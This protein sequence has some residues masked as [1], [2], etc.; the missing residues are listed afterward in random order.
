V[1]SEGL[2]EKVRARCR[3]GSVAALPVFRLN[4]AS[5]ALVQTWQSGADLSAPAQVWRAERSACRE[6]ME[7]VARRLDARG[8]SEHLTGRRRRWAAS[9]IGGWFDNWAAYHR[10]PQAIADYLLGQRLG[11]DRMVHL[12]GTVS[13]N[14]DVAR[15]LGR[16][17]LRRPRDFFLPPPK[18]Q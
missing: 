15:R 14:W 1:V 9:L 2:R 3:P 18:S 5:E 12:A 10:L 11:R 13:R 17:F 8:V 7:Q 6:E 4:G 16:Q